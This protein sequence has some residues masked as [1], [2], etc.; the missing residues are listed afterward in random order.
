MTF[1][2]LRTRRRKKLLA[3]PFPAPWLGYLAGNVRHYRYLEPSRQAVVRNV[4][5][6][7]VAEK[8]W[9][10]GGGL[11]VSEEMKVTVAAQASL[12]VLGFPQLYYYD[13]VPSIILYP[14]AYVLPRRVQH[15]YFI[16]R[17]DWELCGEAWHRGPIVLSWKNVLASGRNADNGRNVVLHEFAHHLDALD[18]DVDGTPPL[19]E[20]QLEDWYRVTEAEYLRLVGN[21]QRNEGTLLD[22]YGATNRVEF[23]A[24]ATECFFE[25]PS[26]M[27]RVHEELYGVLRD[28]YRQDPAQWCPDATIRRR[29]QRIAEADS[30]E[31]GHPDR[32][33]EA[34]L[35]SQLAASKDT[36]NLFLLGIECLEDKQYELAAKAFSD[37]IELDPSDAEARQRRAMARARL[38]EYAAALNDATEALRLDGEDVMGYLA[39]GAAYLGLRQYEQA[40]TDFSRVLH[41]DGNNAEAYYSRGLAHTALGKLRRAASDFSHSIALRPYSAEEYYHRAHAYRRLGYS[42][43]AD[44]DLEK[45]FQ[46][47]PHVG[48]RK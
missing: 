47:D 30:E 34:E 23:F 3:E 28:F 21:A 11:S 39:R 48:W 25:Q 13:H 26:A 10:G 32:A 36:E 8:H 29:P 2:W 15:N 17:E 7:F 44:A 6:V 20:R 24:V 16:V 31:S 43:K 5:R 45:A 9:A 27:K 37:V 35:E 46:L 40:K 1:S 42:A 33:R 19:G 41:E 4:V 22:Q 12:L 14:R 38:G 18:G